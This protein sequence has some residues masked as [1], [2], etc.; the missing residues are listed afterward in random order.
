MEGEPHPSPEEPERAYKWPERPPDE[1]T[2]LGSQQGKPLPS[3]EASAEHSDGEGDK[4]EE[5]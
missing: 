3:G 5:E 4:P 1:F 2:L